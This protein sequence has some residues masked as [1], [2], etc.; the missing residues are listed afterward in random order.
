MLLVL[1]SVKS[2]H[3]S[4]QYIRCFELIQREFA[5]S[6][7]NS[8]LLFLYGK[9]VVRAMSKEITKLT[10]EKRL[11]QGRA[12]APSERA[13]ILGTMLREEFRIDQG[14]LGSGIGA[15]EESV[16]TCHRERLA[17]IN[18]YIGQAYKILK[19][20][21]KTFEFWKVA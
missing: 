4:G 1:I 9:Q 13:S 18:F 10:R 21:L 12:M 17:Q 16:R 20:P 2:L 7:N 5:E 14:F 11:N 19:M 3:R 15:L 8:S 6:P